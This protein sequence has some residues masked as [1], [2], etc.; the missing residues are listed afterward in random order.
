[1]VI[2]KSELVPPGTVVEAK[3][4][5]FSSLGSVAP[6]SGSGGVL[7][8]TVLVTVVPG[9][10]P[11]S[12]FTA[13]VNVSSVPTG[14]LGLVQLTTPPDPTAGVVQVQPLGGFGGEE[15]ETKV[16]PG[17]NWSV[18]VAIAEFCGPKLTTSMV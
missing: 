9:G 2:D 18:K 14:R 8:A 13:K 12:I 15:I 16:V 1:L 3:A 5:L 6:F 11:E 4:V 7:I 17:G 10:V